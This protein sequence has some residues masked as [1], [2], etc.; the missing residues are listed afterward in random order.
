MQTRPP[1]SLLLVVPTPGPPELLFTS[2]R[3]CPVHNSAWDPTL[4]RA[5]FQGLSENNSHPEELGSI[6]LEATHLTSQVLT[7]V[8]GE[9]QKDASV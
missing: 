4:G 8:M 3:T 7:G 2:W 9:A 5:R 6:N 1:G